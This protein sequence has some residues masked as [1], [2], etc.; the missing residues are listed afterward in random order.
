MGVYTVCSFIYLDLL[1]TIIY[2][3]NIIFLYR[4]CKFQIENTFVLMLCI[5]L[6]FVPNAFE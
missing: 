3:I 1:V 6:N 5:L 4:D 2:N